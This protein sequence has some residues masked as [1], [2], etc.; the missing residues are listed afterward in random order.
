M[1]VHIDG[2]AVAAIIRARDAE[3]ER[4]QTLLV[5]IEFRIPTPV[6]DELEARVNYSEV[7]APHHHV[8]LSA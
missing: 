5:D 8:G 1:I 3:R 4:P 7:Q 2:L 6:A